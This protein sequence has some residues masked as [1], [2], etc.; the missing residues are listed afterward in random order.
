[1]IIKKFEEQVKHF[2]EKTA[3]KKGDRELSYGQLNDYADTI[4]RAIITGDRSMTP[5]EEPQQ[6]ALLFEH[7]IDMI[8]AL[9]GA[10]KACKTYVPLDITYPVKRQLYIL[11]NSGAR[12]I[13]TNNLNI[14]QAQELAGQMKLAGREIRILNIDCI[15]ENTTISTIEREAKG[16][17]NAYIIYTSGSTGKPKGVYQTH[18]NVLYYTRNW[19]QCFSISPGDRMT[20]LT[21]FTHDGCVQDIFS[22]LLSGACL[23]PYSLKEGGSIEGLYM[24]L[25]KEKITI[26]HSVP[27]LY[28]F[29]ANSLTEKDLFYDLRWILLG[30]EPLRDYDLRMY[31]DYFPKARLANV[32]GQTESSVSAIC[33]IGPKDTFEDMHLG[34]PLDETK[35]MLVNDDGQIVEKMGGGEIVVSSAYLAPGYW[36]DPE[37]SDIAFTI[38]DELGYLYW[39]GDQGRLTAEGHIKIM[40]RKDFQVKVR[41]FRVETGEIETALLKYETI[42]EVVVTARPDNAGDNYLCAYIVSTGTLTPEEL[43]K[44]LTAELPDYMVPRY[45]LFLEKMPLNFTGK[46]DR[47]SLPDP[48]E[49]NTSESTYEA[50][51][52]EVEEK[53]AAIWQ[54]VLGVEKV[55]ISDNFIQLGGHSL[56]VI[57][58]IARIH[59]EFDVELQLTDIFAKPTV[60]ELAQLIRDTNPSLFS[61][62]VFAEEKEY[63]PLSTNQNGIFALSRFEEIGITYNITGIIPIEGD[64]DH[65]RFE[66]VLLE[67]IKRHEAFRTSFRVIDDRPV[68]V[69]HKNVDFQVLYI[70]AKEK[71]SKIDEIVKEFIR[72]FDLSKAPLFHASVVK[73]AENKHLLLMDTHHIIS[74]GV[75]SE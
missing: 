67:L 31:R 42:K 8:A 64:F 36:Q 62:I 71:S 18:H 61:A 50:P 58:I 45:F 47:Q 24:L 12:L 23:Y 59:Q 69:I 30:G 75:S 33:S 16:D 34:E 1:M 63:Y 19:I 3:I 43:R 73:L 21:S 2:Y 22:A 25:V 72:P 15:E 38:D 60:K 56:L 68:Q 10:L 57:S 17:R 55:G 40:G 48:E 49:I 51:T 37:N 39:T 52:D 4:A 6:A 65:Q 29:F 44:Y 41:G 26:W 53:V 7:G 35:I 54:E 28:R 66:N 9:L 11:E 32:Y 74:D 14:T 70:D 13:L 5:G 20:L 27:S 46:I